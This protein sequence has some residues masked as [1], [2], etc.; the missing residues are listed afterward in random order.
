[1]TIESGKCYY[2]INKKSGTV[3]DLDISNNRAVQCCTRHEG[4]GLGTDNQQ[5]D[6]TEVRNG[7]QIRNAQQRTY[8]SFEGDAH[9]G[10]KIVC[11][12]EPYVWHIWR[13]DK[14]PSAYRICVPNTTQN[15]DLADH[16]KKA[17][18]QLWTQASWEGD[19]QVWCTEQVDV[20]SHQ[21][22]HGP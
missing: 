9:D 19:H 1:M 5:W 16:G 2:I 3:V 7:W 14:D 10:Q 17:I 15:L 20:V 18:V 4:V 6:L 11:R 8:L 13:D 22:T 21:S 12:P